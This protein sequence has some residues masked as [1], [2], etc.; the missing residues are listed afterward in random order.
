ML[1]K[2]SCSG[3]DLGVV[4]L[5][6][7]TA[8]RSRHLCCSQNDVRVLGVTLSSDLTKDKHLHLQCLLGRFLSVAATATCMRRSLD[9]ESAAKLVH[10]FVTS[11]I[12]YCNVT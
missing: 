2:L 1:T 4:I 7:V 11:R 9:S 10:A 6:W 12:D 3:L 8:A 5:L